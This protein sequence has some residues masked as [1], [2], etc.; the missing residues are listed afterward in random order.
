[1]PPG[2]WV[3]L[4]SRTPPDEE[5]PL[6]V[7]RVL[8][9]LLRRKWM[10]ILV[11]LAGTVIGFVLS[12]MQ[13][14]SYLAQATLWIQ[15]PTNQNGRDVG[16][17]PIQSGGLLQ[18]SSWVDLLQSFVV[19]DEVVRQQRFYLVTRNPSDRA[20]FGTLQLKSAFLPADY[21]LDVSKDGRTF[22]LTTGERVV[23]RGAVGDSVG[24]AEGL[25]WVPSARD[26]WPGR[27]VRFRVRDPR[28]AA[29][30][31]RQELEAI[32]P[33]QGSFLRLQ[34]TG[35][36]A[37]ATATTLNAVV[38]RFVEVAA[39]L[40]RQRLSELSKI[41]NEQLTTS[42]TDLRRAESALETFRVHTITLPSEQASPVTPGLEQTR[43][44]VFRS[45]FEM[46]IERDQLDRDRQNIIAALAQRDSEIAAMQ[47]EVIPS[48][49]GSAELST[50]L[51]QLAQKEAEARAM[52][53]QFGSVYPPLQRL[54]AEIGDLQRHSVPE[55][56]Q[57][58]AVELAARVRDDDARIGSASRE[59]QQIPQ[60][61]IEEARLRRDVAIAENLYTTL[62]QRYEEARLAEVSSIPDVRVLDRAVP[63]ER[64]LGSKA[65]MLL[66]V[67][68]VG[69][70][71]LSVVLSLF[72]DRLDRRL[73][74]PEQV[75]DG[76]G[77][78]ILG[79]IPRLRNGNRLAGAET[80][81]QVVEA[82]RSIRLNLQH[83]YGAAGPLVIVISSPAGGDGK[84]F[85]ASNLAVSFADAG[86]RTIVI[87]G[88]IR[89]GSLH[90]VF[91]RPRKPGLIDHL[92]G[93][94]SREE[95]VQKTSIDGVDFIACG[96]RKNAGPELLASAAMSQLLIGLRNQYG[97]IIMDCAPL[98]AGVDP[99]VVG[100]LTGNLVLVLRTGVT[101]REFAMAKLG[102]VS[103]LPIRVLGAVLNDVRPG[104]GYEHYYHYSYL[105]GYE[106]SEESGADSVLRALPGKGS[107]S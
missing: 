92:G 45:F 95:I 60:R 13:P 107:G 54:N 21:R 67:G 72:L 1:M 63:P 65:N 100:T 22:V 93:Q 97:V 29:L 5:Q 49:R 30:T 26:L 73:R 87:D 79:A 37:N 106:T 91:E 42:Y 58:L 43:D 35:P 52:R 4:A 23:Q 98:G 70:L 39:E 53:L 41:L 88:D 59:L 57:K 47:L 11:T 14:P 51:G 19:L 78:P 10:I 48:V 102:A 101:D 85:L 76:M 18:W 90:R 96:T 44:P 28:D 75:T 31:L 32:L 34:L 71:G 7:R 89:R 25:E 27:Q 3:D 94:A 103:R 56:A 12:R 61:A 6:D 84:S 86:H 2:P 62:Q 16:P 104:Q 20:A 15:T 38:D 64:P 17:S 55:L 105:P 74:Y 33:Q 82:L 50:A 68:I 83:A 99:L 40:K 46:R 9:A 66:L 81:A 8:A 77:L 69:G 36:S 80:Q 24:N